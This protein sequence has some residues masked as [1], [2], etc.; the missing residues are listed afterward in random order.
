[1]PTQ[2]R[3][4]YWNIFNDDANED[5]KT[6]VVDLAKVNKAQAD[7]LEKLKAQIN[8]EVESDFWE[9]EDN[10]DNLQRLDATSHGR[11]LVSHKNSPMLSSTNNSLYSDLMRFNKAEFVAI[12]NE[13]IDVI[14]TKMLKDL[15]REILV[16]L[17]QD[18]KF[19]LSD[20]EKDKLIADI[21][22]AFIKDSSDLIYSEVM[23]EVSA[24]AKKEI[25]PRLS[26]STQQSFDQMISSQVKDYLNKQGSV[27]IQKKLVEDTE[28]MIRQELARVR[29]IVEES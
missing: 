8:E 4:E 5:E 11:H 7:M 9:Q 12:K 19:S 27:I 17:K 10:M 20:R 28:V 3:K 23:S 1:M 24:D 26:A 16:E 15:K 25:I 13:I 2:D 6:E 22:K 14:K 21:K 29:K 18:I